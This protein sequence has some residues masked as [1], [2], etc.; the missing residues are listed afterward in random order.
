MS[1]FKDM[2][3]PRL[4]TILPGRQAHRAGAAPGELVLGGRRVSGSD[5]GE[6]KGA[7]LAEA[8]RESRYPFAV[9]PT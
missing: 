8:L 3:K 2:F 6:Q 9:A 7:G 4:F 5:T 1:T